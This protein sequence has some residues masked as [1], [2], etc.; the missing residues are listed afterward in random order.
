MKGTIAVGPEVA[1]SLADAHTQGDVG[2]RDAILNVNVKLAE[3][4][5]S[6]G[7][8]LTQAQKVRRGHRGTD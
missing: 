6:K 1:D 8:L 5:V 3:V 7:G 4:P 2:N